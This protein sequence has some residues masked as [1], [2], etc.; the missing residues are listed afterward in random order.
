[1]GV[2]MLETSVT[3]AAM[4]QQMVQATGLQQYPKEAESIMLKPIK[5]ESLPFQVNHSTRC[6]SY[7]VDWNILT[8][9]SITLSLLSL[10]TY[11]YSGK[12]ICLLRYIHLDIIVIAM[13][14]TLCFPHNKEL[15]SRTSFQWLFCPQKF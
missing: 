5:R 13:Q 6:S 11:H 10:D 8:V 14:C 12:I 9:A 7:L 4:A 15:P 2:G 3:Y 1:M